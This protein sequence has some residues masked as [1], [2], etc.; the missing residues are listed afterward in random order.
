MGR[1][2]KGVIEMRNCGD[3][4]GVTSQG[5]CAEATHVTDE[6]GDNHFNDLQGNPSGRGRMCGR[7]LN[8]SAPG[9][10]ALD[11]G[12]TSVPNSLGE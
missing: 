8:G 7:G 3:V 9:A 2:G 12:Q 10:H 6:M 1:G 4:P 11:S 5:A